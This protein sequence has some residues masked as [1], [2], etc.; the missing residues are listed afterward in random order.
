MFSEQE[1]L[2]FSKSS[3]YLYFTLS[4]ILFYIIS[5]TAHKNL[6]EHFLFFGIYNTMTLGFVLFLSNTFKFK[7]LYAN[8]LYSCLYILF[9]LFGFFDFDWIYLLVLNLFIVLDIKSYFFIVPKQ[10]NSEKINNINVAM[11]FDFNREFALKSLGLPINEYSKTVDIQEELSYL[12]FYNSALQ[13]ENK[14]H[15]KVYQDI[16]FEV[17]RRFVCVVYKTLLDHCRM[18]NLTAKTKPV[19]LKITD[20]SHENNPKHG[21]Y[22][23]EFRIHKSNLKNIR[24]PVVDSNKNK[25]ISIKDSIDELN[26]VCQNFGYDLYLKTGISGTKKE[27]FVIRMVFQVTELK[28]NNERVIREIEG[29]ENN[30]DFSFLNAHEYKTETP[31]VGETEYQ[32][33]DTYYEDNIQA[34]DF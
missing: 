4:V 19:D 6:A 26:Q 10:F 18:G 11:M 23:L 7:N 21:R 30:D 24:V 8:L 32:E 33:T 9:S 1:E 25:T 20:N 2:F 3:Q 34:K 17:P 31:I 28:E 29:A 13:W 14:L 16:H 15:D 12:S 5:I 27:L 22:V